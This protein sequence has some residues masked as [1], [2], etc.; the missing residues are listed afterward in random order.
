MLNR[1]DQQLV[2]EG[3][4][5]EGMSSEAVYFAWGGAYLST[6]LPSATLLFFK[7]SRCDSLPSYVPVRR[8]IGRLYITGYIYRPEFSRRAYPF[9]IVQLRNNYVTSWQ[10]SPIFPLWQ[11]YSR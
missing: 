1:Q 5:E 8:Y 2:L 7:A 11:S 3:R 6:N 4:I 10:Y 9:K